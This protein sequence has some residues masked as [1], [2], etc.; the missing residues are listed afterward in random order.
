[1]MESGIFL[2]ERVQ[3]FCSKHGRDE[4]AIWQIINDIHTREYGRNIMWEKHQEEHE[5]NM[6]D[7]PMS[8]FF[9]QKELVHNAISILKGL[10]VCIANNWELG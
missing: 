8:Q 1:M 9:A 2:E 6:N 5:K 7:I 4:G 3:E 10:E